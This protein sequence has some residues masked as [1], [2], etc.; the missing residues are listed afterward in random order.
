MFPAWRFKQSL[1]YSLQLYSPARKQANFFSDGQREICQLKC[2]YSCF[3]PLRYQFLGNKKSYLWTLAHCCLC[4][5]YL[6]AVWINCDH[7]IPLLAGGC[8]Y[9]AVQCFFLPSACCRQGRE[10]CG[11]VAPSLALFSC[12]TWLQQMQ[13]YNFRWNAWFH[14]KENIIILVLRKRSKTILNKRWILILE[15]CLPRITYRAVHN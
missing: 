12:F 3:L 14:E 7:F 4:I 15:I 10:L 9:L 6:V 13:I 8:D 1:V 11:Q 5:L 2:V